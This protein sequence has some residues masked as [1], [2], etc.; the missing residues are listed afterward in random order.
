MTG[1]VAYSRRGAAEAE[2]IEAYLAE[3]SPLAAERFR[4]D[5]ERAERLL[6][7]FPNS[8]APGVRPPFGRAHLGGLDVGANVVRGDG[9]D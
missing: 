6:A 9:R 4:E 2:E 8:G 7:Q 1:R 5:L 3:H